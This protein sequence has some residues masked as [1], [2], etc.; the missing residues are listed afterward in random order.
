MR[1]AWQ[2][3]NRQT[4]KAKAIIHG[5]RR[6]ERWRATER[7]RERNIE[8]AAGCRT[9]N[10]RFTPLAAVVVV[11]FV[12]VVVA[13]VVAAIVTFHFAVSFST[14]P[15]LLMPCTPT[16]CLLHVKRSESAT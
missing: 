9:P 12:D 5:E 1:E 15:Y 4:G 14:F 11:V 6:R 16:D 2:V 10:T 8:G 3:M 13:T 7:E